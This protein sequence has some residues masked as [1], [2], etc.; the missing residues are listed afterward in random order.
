MNPLPRM[1][2]LTERMSA[3]RC[4]W[5]RAAGRAAGGI[6]LAFLLVSGPPAAAQEPAAE[7]HTNDLSDSEMLARLGELLQ[8]VESGQFDNLERPENLSDTNEV[9]PASPAA[10]GASRPATGAA[11]TNGTNRFPGSSRSQKDARH[12]RGRRSARPSDNTRSSSRPA[13]DPSPEGD[14]RPAAAPAGTNSRPAS[15]DF[16]AFKIIADRNIFDPNRY[17][18]RAGEPRVRPAPKVIDT[19]TLVGTMSYE[20]GWFAFF[21]GS[22]SE[23]R[24]ALQ[25]RDTIAGYQVAGI[26][27][28]NVALAGETNRL[29]LKVGTQLRREDGGPW[30]LASPAEA[31]STPAASTAT[32]TTATAAAPD[33]APAASDAESD[34][35]KRLMQKR[36]EE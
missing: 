30:R 13:G 22:S 28:D 8:A 27:P 17:A 10:P 9:S 7:N 24:K 33:A 15:L 5:R 11:A 29:E 19:V 26:A 21:D 4:R 12:F 34:I 18:H 23:F 36:L 35:I 25:L 20:K 3:R 14:R 2:L 1:S 6:L 31:N 32:N 16:S